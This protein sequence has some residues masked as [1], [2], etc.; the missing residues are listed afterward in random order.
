MNSSSKKPEPSDEDFKFEV[1]GTYE[2]MKGGYE[3]VS[4]RN[5]SMVIRWKDGTEANTSV[6]LQKRILDRMAF[7]KEK[8]QAKKQEKAKKK[9]SRKQ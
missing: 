7:E 5:D 4:I 6:E 9:K 1:G 3:V 8:E 2:N